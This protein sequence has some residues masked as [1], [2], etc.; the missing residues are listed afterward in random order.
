MLSCGVCV[1]V[2]FMH[3]VKT[4]KDIFKI[5]SPSGSHTI[6]VFPYQTAWQYSHR[7]PLMGVSNACGVGWNHDS[8]P[9]SGFTAVNAATGQVLWIRRHRTTS[10]KLWHFAGSNRRCLLT[11]GKDGEMSIKS[12]LVINNVNLVICDSVEIQWLR[13]V[14]IN[15]QIPTMCAKKM[16]FT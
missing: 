9:V 4:N 16:R 11:A 14:D 13:V 2:T 12:R 5:F 7:N 6:L 15:H 3:S 10:H 1:S 8:E